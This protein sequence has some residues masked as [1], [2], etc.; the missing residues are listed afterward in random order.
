M[1]SGFVEDDSLPANELFAL[2]SK[3][4]LY[5]FRRQGKPIT[6]IDSQKQMAWLEPLNLGKRR[7]R[8]TGA[9]TNDRTI[10]AGAAYTLEHNLQSGDTRRIARTTPSRRTRRATVR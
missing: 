4:P 9:R 10:L 5:T 1:I 2:Q 7:F 3:R 6:I 8:E